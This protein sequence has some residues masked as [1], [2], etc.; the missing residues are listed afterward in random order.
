[1]QLEGGALATR[2]HSP[3]VALPATAYTQAFMRQSA[4]ALAHPRDDQQAQV[5]LPLPQQLAPF[6][7]ESQTD[8]NGYFRLRKL[9]AGT[10]VV[11]GRLSV[12]F[13]RTV[14]AEDERK[15]VYDYSFVWLE[16]DP[17]T[18]RARSTSNVTF[19][20]A[21]RRNKMSSAK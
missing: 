1:V 14:G 21:A 17:V 15:I 6:A 9:P 2:A 10:Y 18:V 8:E 20:I 19:H 11:R 12:A 4:I 16:S 3:I 7:R 5:E 13:P